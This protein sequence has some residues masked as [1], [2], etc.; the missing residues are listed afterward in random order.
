M[1]WLRDSEANLRNALRPTVL[2]HGARFATLPRGGVIAEAGHSLTILEEFGYGNGKQPS[3]AVNSQMPSVRSKHTHSSRV[4]LNSAK[5][6]PRV[7]SAL[8]RI[9]SL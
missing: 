5:L 1:E 2:A 9:L 8:P 7:C 3:S 4:S 6:A